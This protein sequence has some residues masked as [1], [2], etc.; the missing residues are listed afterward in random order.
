M[1]TPGKPAP[2]SEKVPPGWFTRLELQNAWGVSTAWAARLI[3]SAVN[4]GTAT[5]KKF[6]IKRPS[7]MVFPT[8]HYFFKA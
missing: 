5:M 4:D 6:R 2:K 1:K 3:E 8:P 7:G